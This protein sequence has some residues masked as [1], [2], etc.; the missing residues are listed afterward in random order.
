MKRNL[1]FLVMA[2][3]LPAFGGLAD[4]GFLTEGEHEWFITWRSF[5]PPLVVDGGGALEIS[6]RDYGR[7]IIKSTSKPLNM[8]GGG[9]YDILL[10]DNA[11]LEYLNGVTEFIRVTQNN[12]VELKGGSVNSIK[13]MRYAA[14]GNENIF[15][16]AFQDSWSWIDG[17]RNKGI[18]GYWL[19][20][21]KYFRIEFFNDDVF[22]T[23]PV[24]M[25][26]KVIPE[27]ATFLL[28]GIGGLLLRKRKRLELEIK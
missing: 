15:I 1:V 26:V 28:I 18:Q 25:S 5:S 24:W 3:S 4:D 13:T 14:S 10:F 9:V 11:Q 17:D 7:L 22:G 27:P 2:I 12:A 21:G 16:H 20:D 6:V 8:D 19:A 23:D